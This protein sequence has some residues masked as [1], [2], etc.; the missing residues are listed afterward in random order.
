MS[1][2]AGIVRSDGAPV[3]SRLL[4]SMTRS[5]SFRGPEAQAMWA[6]GPAGLG[7]AL[8]RT[9]SETQVERQPTS[10]DQK[11]WIVA[12]V[13]LDARDQLIADLR[14]H[15]RRVDRSNSDSELILH[16]YEAWGEACIEHL[17]GDFAFAIW[18]ARQHQLIC[19]RD[20]FGIKPFYYAEL[21]G[22]FVFSNTLDCIRLHPS[23]GDELNDAAIVDFLMFGLNCD[24]ASTSFSQIRRL[25][26]AQTL[27]WSA[28]GVQLRE[29]WQPPTNGGVRYRRREEYVENFR[30]LLN[31]AIEDRLRTKKA[32]IFLSGGLD[33]SAIAALARGVQQ[34]KCPSLELH[35]F[36]A[37]F[38]GMTDSDAPAARTVA[39]ALQI[40]YHSWVVDR[41][42]LFERW[43]E[44]GFHF[45]EPVDDPF[46]AGWLDSVRMITQNV[47]VAL[48][49]EGCDNLLEFEMG[50]HFRSLWSRGQFGRAAFDLSEH[51]FQR[52][53]APDGIRGPLRRIG[54]MFAGRPIK[55]DFCRCINPDLVARLNLTDRRENA[56]AG[57]RKN[58]HP[59]HP[60]AYASL[61]L[62]QWDYMFE[63]FDAG[64]TRQPLE[65]RYPFLDLRLVNFL[66]AIPV[67]PWSFRK[68]LLRRA[69][70]GRLPEAIRMRPK[71]PLQENP[72]T[73]AV[74]RERGPRVQTMKVAEELRRYINVREIAP[75]QSSDD[76]ELINLKIRIR[77]LNHWL[78]SFKRPNREA[79]APA[80]KC[81]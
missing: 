20:H 79:C 55:I 48:Y 34:D 59:D 36:T 3:D 57:T 5:L 39:T 24:A 23:V 31:T 62:P 63:H 53:V 56:F 22:C 65:V 30:E 52:F 66:L 26:R 14:A 8:L 1:G 43:E 6:D 44:S 69:M 27:R 70:R 75:L 33:S 72:V 74:R 2:I 58:I 21:P 9:T 45:P 77:G 67:M 68:Y 4:D 38:E 71:T 78:Q 54:N 80:L 32:G 29:Y 81:S 60:R 37:T 49:G 76:P 40:P 61:F 19:A 17:L 11:V 47:N 35:A 42:G 13:R 18:D 12:D 46:A 15:G 73:V 28:S 16:A 51:I 25:P 7:C 50:A 10:L 41:L 64:M